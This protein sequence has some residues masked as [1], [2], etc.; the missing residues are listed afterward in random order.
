[1]DSARSAGTPDTVIWRPLDA[2]D[3]EAVV[4]LMREVESVDQEGRYLGDDMAQ[5]LADPLQD[6]ARGS[7]AALDGDGIV[8]FATLRTGEL[9]GPLSDLRYTG[10]VR[11]DHR[12]RGFG[13]RLLAWVPSGAQAL[14]EARQFP[15]GPI[16]IFASLAASNTDAAR[17][18]E[19]FGY[20]AVRRFDRMTRRLDE[21]LPV[22]KPLDGV[23]IVPYSADR[24]EEARRM[25][26]EAFREHWRSVPW[27]PERWRSQAVG[28]P[29][30]QPGLS[31]LALDSGS[32]AVV[33][34]VIVHHRAA[35]TEATGLRN[36][37]VSSIS[38]LHSHRGRGIAGTLL[39][40]V[41]N[42]AKSQGFDTSSLG[43][44]A[45]NRDRAAAVYEKAG[46]VTVSSR[47][48][49]SLT[50]AG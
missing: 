49:Y 17:L 19:S 44:D 39:A 21:P 20:A 35:Q 38:T 10:T 11:P 42:A 14:R 5:W 8:A 30:F 36:A 47:F 9:T 34:A 31:F 23:E 25:K 40:S 26:N 22:V 41:L 24:D 13:A 50:V 33:G 48:A 37:Y 4:G 12:G 32:G 15:G 6:L 28:S 16:E 27:S 43:V 1:M 3:A 2:S 7:I 46:Y 18:H 45:E 29:E